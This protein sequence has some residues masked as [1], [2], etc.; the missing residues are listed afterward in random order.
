M[1]LHE[2][3]LLAEF[4]SLLIPPEERTRLVD[5]TLGEGGHAEAAL[6]ANPNLSLAGVEKDEQVLAR[7]RVRLEAYGERVQLFRYSF[8]A[9]FRSYDRLVGQPPDRI[10]FDLGVSMFHFESSGRGFSFSREEPLDMRLDSG[11]PLRA[12]DIVNELPEQ[13]LRELIRRYGEER[14]A[15][16]I[17]RAIVRARGRAP[18]R[19]TRALAE[20]VR[21]AVPP[22]YRYGRIHPATR[23]FQA[24]RIAVN[25]E[26]DVLQ[27]ALPPAF[28]VLRAG[29]RMGVISFHSLEDRIVKRFFAQCI[30]PC[31]CPPETPIC[32]CEGQ[33]RA[34]LL[35]R[36]PLVPGEEERAR[37]PASRS[38]K[39]RVLEKV[40]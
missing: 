6:K 22:A 26:L 37:N 23:T 12:A 31:T 4:L 18:L 9:F 25:G 40:A 21:S 33:R 2:P 14:L 13:E 3:V 34:R 1:Y 38:A 15:G 30:R 8:E 11:A 16:P 17:A 19:T 24:L 10:F 20:V 27:E 39:L 36:R 32:Q 7:A 29:G 35:T 5:A 28:E